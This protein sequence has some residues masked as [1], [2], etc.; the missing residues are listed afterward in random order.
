MIVTKKLKQKKKKK[1]RIN[2]GEDI[3]KLELLA[4]LL[5]V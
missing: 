3:E 2:V 4:L 5:N 1:Q